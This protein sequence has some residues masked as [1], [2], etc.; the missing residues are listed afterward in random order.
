MSQT[1]ILHFIR[2]LV[3][4]LCATGL[5]ATLAACSS[6]GRELVTTTACRD[7]VALTRTPDVGLPYI[8]AEYA[9]QELALNA[10]PTD[11]PPQ[12]F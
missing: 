2:P 8:G 3:A 1:S 11:A 4:S 10:G 9:D 5:V 12:G 6:K 7:I